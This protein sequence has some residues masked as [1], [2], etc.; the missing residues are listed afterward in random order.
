MSKQVA[1]SVG[2]ALMMM[3]ALN[4][5]HIS[6]QNA[7]SHAC[8][9][10]T[11]IGGDITPGDS[12]DELSI[13]VTPAPADKKARPTRYST[14]GLQISSSRNHYT[15]YIYKGKKVLKKNRK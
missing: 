4:M 3:L 10:S 11:V 14:N 12:D 8:D 5:P 15:L 9:S 1:T 6:A 13:N 2:A 7:T